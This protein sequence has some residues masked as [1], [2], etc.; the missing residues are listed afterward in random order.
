[1]VA[2]FSSETTFSLEADDIAHLL[3][4]FK[5]QTKHLQNL[6]SVLTVKNI[7]LH[8]GAYGN[9]LYFAISY[10]N[11]SESANKKE[12]TYCLKAQKLKNNDWNLAW[13]LDPNYIAD[14]TCFGV[15]PKELM[16]NSEGMGEGTKEILD[17]EDIKS[18]IAQWHEINA[19]W[20]KVY[21]NDDWAGREEEAKQILLKKLNLK[22]NS[23][24][25]H[26]NWLSPI[27]D[28]YTFPKFKELN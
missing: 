9:S 15:T 11:N 3:D 26:E 6:N 2:G 8:C 25:G 21:L 19:K 1:M 14:Q 28:Y 16:I 23:S 27:G 17:R 20:I 7:S 12:S 4:F 18:M 22:N 13:G 10:K 24:I 5:E